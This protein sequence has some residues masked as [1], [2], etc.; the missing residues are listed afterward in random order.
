MGIGLS[1]QRKRNLKFSRF[2]PPG[3]GGAPGLLW[4]GDG[5]GALSQVSCLFPLHLSNR[6]F[7]LPTTAKVYLFA[8]KNAK[9]SAVFK[10]DNLEQC[11]KTEAPSVCCSAVLSLT[12]NS[13]QNS[14]IGAQGSGVALASVRYR[15]RPDTCHL[16]QSLLKS[17]LLILS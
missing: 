7:P 17:L 9:E 4:A 10:M 3:G 15:V 12:C 5:M 14:C 8:E 6:G 11:L 2:L 1:L 13:S 16:P